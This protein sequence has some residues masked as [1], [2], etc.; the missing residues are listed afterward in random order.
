MFG[1]PRLLD[2]GLTCG[3]CAKR[4]AALG[5]GF[6]ALGEDGER[7]VRIAAEILDRRVEIGAGRRE[8]LPVGRNLVFE[9]LSLPMT[10]RP[11]IS[12]GRSVSEFAATSASRISL[13]LCPSTD[14]TFHPHASYFMATFSV[15]TSSTFVE[16]WMLFES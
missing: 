4:F 15:M 16:S 5:E 11:M 12:V 1:A 13:M 8:R 9:A 10:V 7:I 14:S 2:L 3:P 6:A